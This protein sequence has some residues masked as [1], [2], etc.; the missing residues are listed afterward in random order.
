M[1]NNPGWSYRV[2]AS[3]TVTCFSSCFELG[4]LTYDAAHAL[5]KIL[6]VRDPELREIEAVTRGFRLYAT[7]LGV[8]LAEI[9][10]V[11]H[12][13]DRLGYEFYYGSGANSEKTNLLKNFLDPAIYELNDHQLQLSVEMQM[14]TVEPRQLTRDSLARVLN[15]LELT[16]KT[17]LDLVLVLIHDLNFHVRKNFTQKETW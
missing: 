7:L 6:S 10:H 1:T 16:R 13:A 5:A 17:A 11:V 15:R 8:C 4:A 12:K 2:E 9:Q 3:S 14:W